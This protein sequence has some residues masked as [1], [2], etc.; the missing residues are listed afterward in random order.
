VLDVSKQ[1]VLEADAD[2]RESYGQIGFDATGRRAVVVQPAG[3]LVLKTLDQPCLP[4]E[5]GQSGPD[6]NLWFTEYSANSIGRMTTAGVVT[7]FPLPSGGSF[8]YAITAGP[9]GNVWFT[10]AAGNAIGKITPAGVITEYPIPTG[11]SGPSDISVGPTATRGSP[12]AIALAGCR[13][14]AK[15]RIQP[16]ASSPSFHFPALT[17]SLEGLPWERTETLF[18]GR[19]GEQRLKITIAESLRS[20]HPTANSNVV[21]IVAGPDG[22]LW[23]TE[24]ANQPGRI[25][26]TE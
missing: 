18:G 8:P 25:T 1:A 20:I 22:N 9:D 6:G 4:P 12:S 14:V 5:E 24:Y 10:E 23:F 11:G 7:E 15:S 26:T 19:S 2:A 13:L 21:S 3:L 17:A 16:P